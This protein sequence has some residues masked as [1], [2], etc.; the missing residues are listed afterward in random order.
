MRPA[1]HRAVRVAAVTLTAAVCF[2]A[3]SCGPLSRSA[4]DRELFTIDA[5]VAGAGFGA[6]P[7]GPTRP[8]DA[9]AI[10]ASAGASAECPHYASGACRW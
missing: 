4:A 6:T 7:A 1:T 10:P 2:F 5:V 8:P 3:A 9:R